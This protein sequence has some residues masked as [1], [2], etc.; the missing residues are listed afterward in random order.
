MVKLYHESD[1]VSGSYNN[2]YRA[3]LPKG[4]TTDLAVL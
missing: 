2:S 4:V 3:Y 1:I